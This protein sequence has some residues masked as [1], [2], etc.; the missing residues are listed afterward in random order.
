MTQKLMSVDDIFGGPAPIDVD[1][2]SLHSEEARK[3]IRESIKAAD[4]KKHDLV[5]HGLQ[6]EEALSVFLDSL[7]EI[8]EV[9]SF[10]SRRKS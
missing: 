2:E 4:W 1:L 10:L 9:R 5:N 7:S 6:P 3:K 8:D